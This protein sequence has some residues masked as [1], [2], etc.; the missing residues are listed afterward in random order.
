MKESNLFRLSSSFVELGIGTS[1][2]VCLCLHERTQIY[3]Y[4]WDLDISFTKLVGPILAL[5]FGEPTEEICLHFFKYASLVTQMQEIGG[6][7][8]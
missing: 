6:S 1:W 5:Q 4:R 8:S 2:H 7:A 3:I